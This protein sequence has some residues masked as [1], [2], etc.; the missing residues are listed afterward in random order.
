MP[1][2][3]RMLLMAEYREP[4][5]EVERQMMLVWW[6]RAL[7]NITGWRADELAMYANAFRRAQESV[8]ARRAT[9]EWLAWAGLAPEGAVTPFEEDG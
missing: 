4:R 1:L 2:T 8:R 5:S 7:E 3:R 6:C 9:N